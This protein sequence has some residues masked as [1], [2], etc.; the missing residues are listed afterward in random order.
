MITLVVFVGQSDT[1]L[2]SLKH[3]L[4][5]DAFNLL[6]YPLIEVK[7]DEYEHK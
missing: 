7:N 6:K 1:I 5:K 4:R 3:F 2:P